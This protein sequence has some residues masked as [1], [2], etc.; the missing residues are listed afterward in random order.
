M[1]L[2]FTNDQRGQYPASWYAQTATPLPEF[3]TLKGETRADLCVIGGGYTGLSAALHAA[4]AGVDVVL[5][6]AQRVGFGASGRNGGQVGSGYNASQRTLEAKLGTSD[7]RKLWDMAEA[8]K[9]L[10]RDLVA[11]HAPDAGYRPGVLHACWQDREVKEAHDEAAWMADT[12]GVEAECLDRDGV[13]EI[14]NAPAYRGGVLDMSAGHLHPLRYAFGLARAADAA[15]VR[16]FERAWAHQIT[17]G[18]QVRVATETGHV[19]ADHVVIA[20]NGYSAGLD[21]KLSARVMPINNF[22]VATEPL[23]DRAD[24][25]L[26]RDIA[27]ADSKF[28][29]NYF[30]L[31]E[32][33]RLLFGGGETYS[34]K[35]PR[36]IAALVRRPLE[37]VFPHLKGVN[38]T[39]AWGGTLAI[40]MSRLPHIGRPAPNILSAAGFSGHGVALAGFTGKL[41]ADAIRGEGAGLDLFGK[42]PT[43]PFPGGGLLRAPLLAL[44]MSWYA[45]RDRLGI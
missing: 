4:Q 14:L 7:A 35:F 28:V 44:A 26:R 32:D 33:K 16:I 30:R 31:T 13:Q 1:N 23:G 29:I 43:P 2:L 8:A 3:P 18:A 37:E 15:G 25:V 34:Y 21:R 9:T 41:M 12:Y 24:E 40:T 10:T 17:P 38:V 6:E 20:T 45:L 42:L 22:I 39:H 5:L 11:A 27:V 36:D 19:L